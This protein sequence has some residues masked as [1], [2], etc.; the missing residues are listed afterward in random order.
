MFL[1]L[2]LTGNAG[3][4]AVTTTT[5]KVREP[6]KVSVVSSEPLEA[7]NV[8]LSRDPGGAVQID[9]DPVCGTRGLTAL[10]SDGTIR[11]FTVGAMPAPVELRQDEVRVAYP[12]WSGD[13]G[14]SGPHVIARTTMSTPLANVTSI[15]EMR[16]PVRPAA[17][18]I[19]AAVVLA[20]IGGG[21]VAESAFAPDP[22]SR[23]ILI[24]VGAA[25]FAAGTAVSSFFVAQRLAPSTEVSTYEAP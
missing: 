9:S 4:I 25:T 24:S 1:A 23:A 19:V 11:M 17:L 13:C 6:A 20:A 3:C 5:V 22:R 8:R 16:T 12:Y 10:R 15:R 21:I 7:A 2:T 18:S 14:R